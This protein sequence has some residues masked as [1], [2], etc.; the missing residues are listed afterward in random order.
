MKLNLKLV[1]IYSLNIILLNNLVL[2]NYLMNSFNINSIYIILI[3]GIISI[4]FILI[5]P[6]DLNKIVTS[7]KFNKTFKIILGIYLLFMTIFTLAIITYHISERFFYLTP[8]FLIILFMLYFIFLLLK[9][10]LKQL[11][12]ILLLSFIIILVISSFHLFNKAN[13]DLYFLKDINFSLDNFHLVLLLS[14]FLF[15]GLI[16]LIISNY[17]SDTISKKDIIISIIIGS[18]FSSL[19]ILQSYSYI[20]PDYYN[21][22]NYPVLYRF[23]IYFG[24]KYIEHFDNFLL[25][26]ISFF[27]ISKST[28]YLE[29]FRISFNFKKTIYFR[30]IIFILL[31][32]ILSFLFY[33]F[34]YNIEHLKIPLII[35]SILL[36]IIY[37]FFLIRRKA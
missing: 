15:D 20:T 29:L 6:K 30:L 18:I 27:I 11:S 28:I 35:I 13:C 37:S 25:L 34:G 22:M 23:R 33:N 31:C 8:T 5:L 36:Y 10:D 12:N 16:F 7:L 21:S 32:L 14:S 19:F 26:V 24:P 1:L 4:I 9:I 17:T 2:S 3:M